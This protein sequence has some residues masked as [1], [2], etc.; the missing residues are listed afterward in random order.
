MIVMHIGDWKSVT[1]A[2]F[3]TSAY[4]SHD[5]WPLC[6]PSFA[7]GELLWFG[8]LFFYTAFV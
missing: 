1:G 8:K 3:K 5:L 2:S 6:V 7:R 4:R